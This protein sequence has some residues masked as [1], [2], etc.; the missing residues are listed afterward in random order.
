MFS[1]RVSG[2]SLGLRL[3]RF[4]LFPPEPDWSERAAIVCGPDDLANLVHS[5]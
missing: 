2:A 5:Q 1:D 3:C 4:L